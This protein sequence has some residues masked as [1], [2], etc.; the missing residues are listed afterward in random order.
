MGNERD[1]RENLNDKAMDERV[2]RFIQ[3]QSEYSVVEEVNDYRDSIF[4]ELK[5][6]QDLRFTE[7]EEQFGD[8][9]RDS[10]IPP[11]EG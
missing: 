2:A 11:Y 8:L 4:N 5:V 3:N 9:R 7:L 10:N 6:M 1:L